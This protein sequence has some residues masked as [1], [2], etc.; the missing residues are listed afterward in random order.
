MFCLI[1]AVT[2][3]QNITISSDSNSLVEGSASSVTITGTID[4]ASDSDIIIP[5]TL[6]GT[7]SKGVDYSVSF[8]SFESASSLY[9]ADGDHRN[10]ISLSDGRYIIYENGTDNLKIIDFDD[11]SSQADVSL[12]RSY[13]H[14]KASSDLILG[15]TSDKIYQL[16][17]SGNTVSESLY[18]ELEDSQGVFNNQISIEGSNI[19]FNSLNNSGERNV[20]LKQGSNEPEQIY[21]GTSC[22][23]VPVLFQ[24]RAIMFG[25]NQSYFSEI[26]NNSYTQTVY[27]NGPSQNGDLDVSRDDIKVFNNKIYVKPAYSIHGPVIWEVNVD[28]GLLTPVLTSPPIYASDPS[29]ENHDFTF[30]SSGNLIHIIEPNQVWVTSFQ[31]APE[32]RIPAGSTSGTITFSVID[33]NSNESDE[34]IIITPGT[35]TNGTLADNSD[36]N[37]TISDDD[38]PSVV[39][40]AFS[41]ETVSEPNGSVTLTATANP[42]SGLDIT[43]PLTLSGTASSDEYSVSASE[44]VIPAGSDSASVTITAVDDTEVEEMQTIIFTIGE[45]TNGTTVTTDVTL[46]LDSDDDP[47]ITSIVG[48]PTTFAENESS[49]VSATINAVSS[50]DI[51]IPFTLS[52]TATS[53]SDY[54]STFDS[55]GEET[56]MM[57]INENNNEFSGFTY[58][59]GKYFFLDWSTLRVFDPA[60]QTSNTYYLPEGLNSQ[61]KIVGNFIYGANGDNYLKKVDISDLNN[62]TST[63]LVSTNDPIS[64]QGAFN[65]IDGTIYYQTY[66][67]ITGVW[68]VYS[69]VEGENSVQIDV[70]NSFNNFIKLGETL[71]GI[72]GWSGLRKYENGEFSDIYVSS[73]YYMAGNNNAKVINDKLYLRNGNSSPNHV[74]YGEIVGSSIVYTQLEYNTSSDMNSIRDF[75]FDSSNG[76]L[77]LYN[78]SS[79]GVYSVFS[80]Q[81]S[82]E[83]KIP[84]GSTTGTI[85]FT[86]VEDTLDEADETLILTPGTPTNGTLSDTSEIILTITDLNDPS[87]VTFAFSAETVSEPNG[88]V[89]LT[90]TADPVSGLDV[91]IPFTLSGTAGS[92]EYSVSASEIVIPAGSDSASVTITALDDDEVEVL[93]T[94]IFTI[95]ELTNGTTET[96]EVTLNLESD[97]DPDVTSIVGSPTTFAENESSTVTATINAASSRDVIIPLTISGTATSETDFTSTFDSEEEET[98]VNGAFGYREFMDFHSDGR[99][100][101]INSNTLTIYEPLNASTTTYS[102]VRS[103]EWHQVEGD[104]IYA[105]SSSQGLET[106]RIDISDLNNIEE[107][108]YIENPT[109]GIAWTYN[110]LSVENGN[111]LYNVYNSNA[112]NSSNS[113][114]VFKKEPGSDPEII[115]EGSMCCYAPILYNDRVYQIGEYDISEIVNGVYTN[116]RYHGGQ[117]SDLK[118]IKVIDGKIYFRHDTNNISYFSLDDEGAPDDGTDGWMAGYIN[119]TNVLTIPNN[120]NSIYTFDFD[121]QMN[122]YTI[123]WRNNEYNLFSYQLSPEIKIPAGSTTGTITFTGVEDTLDEADETLILTPGTPTNGTLSDA[124]ALTLTIT[125]I[126]D[127][128]AVTF[129]FSAETVSEP[130]GSVTLTATADPVS[131]FDI[132]VP[133]TLSGTASSDQYSV[134]ATEIVIPAGSYSASV[135]ITAVDDTEVE[136]LETIVFTIGEVTNGTTE[137]T[138]VTL[139][140]GSEDQPNSSLVATNP[141]M[142]EGESTSITLEIDAAT[143]NDVIVPLVL[144][145]TAT[146]NIDYTTDFETEGQETFLMNVNNDYNR[147]TILDDGRVVFLQSSSIH[148]YDTVNKTYQNYY[149]DEY[150]NYLQASGDFIYLKSNQRIFKFNIDQFNYAEDGTNDI[151]TTLISGSDLLGSNDYYAGENIT[152]EGDKLLYQVYDWPNGYKVYSKEGENDAELIYEGGTHANHLLLFNDRVYKFESSGMQELY[153]GEYT[154]Y[155]NYDYHIY[156]VLAYNNQVY[157]LV[158][159]YD[160]NLGQN[161]RKVSKLNIETDIINANGDD[162]TYEFMP[163]V[164]GD[165]FDYFYMFGFDNLGN[166]VQFNSTF[167]NDNYAYGLYSYQLFPEILISA[168]ETSGTFTFESIEDSSF[169]DDETIIVTPGD[170]IN[171]TITSEQPLELNIIDDDNPP[172]ITFELSSETIVENSETSVTLTA[173]ADVQ[174]G[175]EITIPFTMGGDALADEY[176]L[177]AE[178][179]VIA[180]NA[181]TGSITVTTFGIDDNAVEVSESIVFT[182]GEITNA[183]T[184]TT[185]ITLTL[186]S[187]DNPTVSSVDISQTELTEGESTTLTVTVD[188]AGSNDV[189]VPIIFGGSATTEVDYNSTFSAQGEQSLIGQLSDNGFSR[190]GILSDGRHVF[191]NSSEIRIMSADASSENS[192]QLGSSYWWMEIE[193][194]TIYIANNDRIAIVD[195]TDISSNQVEV[196]EIVALDNVNINGYNFSVENGKVLYGVSADGSGTRQVWL[197]ESL[198]TDPVLLGSG[199]SCCYKPILYNGNV[200]RFETGGYHQLIDGEETNFVSYSGF[201]SYINRDRKMVVKNGILYGF[202]DYNSSD[203]VQL[204]LDA[205]NG[206]VSQAFNIDIGEEINTTRT[207]DFAPNGNI[208]LVNEVIEN[209]ETITQLNSYLMNAE[210]KVDAGETTG[211][212]TINTIDD[213]SFEFDE[214]ITVNYGTP[215]NANIGD[216]QGSEIIILD[217]DLPPVVTFELSSDNIVE[218][219]TDPVT[220][221]ATLSE[222]SGYDVT[223]PFTISGTAG[224]DEYSVSALSIVIPAGSDS[225]SV[226]VSTAELDDEEVEMLETIIFT[227]GELTNASTETTEIILNLE[228]DDDPNLVSVEADPLE[229]AEHESATVTATIDQASSRDVI[230]P[231][232]LSGTAIFDTDY[233]VD[234][235]ALGEENLFNSLTE[236]YTD[237][238][239]LEDGRLIV[240]KSYYELLIFEL[241]GSITSIPLETNATEFKVRGSEIILRD[242]PTMSKIDLNTLTQSVIGATFSNNQIAQYREGFDYVNNK[243]FTLVRSNDNYSTAIHSQIQGE[244]LVVIGNFND[245]PGDYLKS[246]AVTSDEEIF[247]TRQNENSIYKLVDGELQ[248]WA[249]YDQGYIQELRIFNDQLYAKTYS[250][251]DGLNHVVLIDQNIQY[252]ITSD[253]GANIKQL[254]YQLSDQVLYVN[255]FVFYNNDLYLSIQNQQNGHQI[256]SYSFNPEIVIPSGNLSG[257]LLIEGIDDDL[258]APGEETDET[259]EM[260]I[261]D[262]LN[263]NIE[264]SNTFEDITLTILNNEIDLALDED[265]LANVPAMTSSSVAWGDFD[266]DGDQDMAVMGVSFFDGVITRLYENVEGIF[267][268]SNPGIFAPTYEGDLMWVDYNKDG[269]IDLVVSGLDPND[270]PSTVIYEN[271]DG[272]T[273]SPS[274]DMTLPNLFSTS[275]D[276]GDLD[277]DGDIDFIINGQDADNNWRKY[278]YKREGTQL[279]LEGDYN[280]QFNG[281]QGYVDGVMRIADHS[282]DGDLD[283]YMLGQ[284]DSRIKTNTYINESSEQNWWGDQL[285]NVQDGSMTFFGDYVY[286]MGQDSDGTMRFY[287]RSLDGYNNDQFGI[288]GLKDGDIAIGDYNNDGYEDMVITGENESAESITKLYDGNAFGFTENTEIDLVGLRSSTAKWVDYDMDGDLDL[289]LNGT[290]DEGEFSLLYKTNLENKTN[291]AASAITNLSFENLG[292]GKVRLSWDEPEDDFSNNLGYVIRLGTT[293]F[294]SELSNTESNLETGQRLIT[295][296]TQINSNS[297]EALLDP[298]NYYWSVQSVDTGLRGSV[299]SDEATFQLTYEWKL[300]NQGGII[301][302]SISSIDQPIVKLTDIDGDNDM[303]LVYGSR[304]ADQDIQIFRLGDNSFEYFDY[305]NDARSITDIEFLD[306]NNDLVLDIIVNTWNGPQSNF[307]RLYNSNSNGG[308]NSV[309]SAPGLYQAK[310]ELIDINNDG[311]EEIIHAGRTSESA[312]SELKIYVYEQNGNTLTDQPLDIS[313]QVS[314]LKQGAF[315]FG[316]IDLDEDIDFG[317]TGLSNFG[318]QSNVYLNETVFTET[319]APIFALT[320]VDFPAAYESTLDFIDFDGDGDLDIMLTGTGSNGPMFKVFANN[321]LGGDQLDFTEAQNTGLTPIRNA[322]IDYGDYNGD[323]YLDILYTGTVTGQGEV[324]KLME[325]DPDT[326]S[327]IESDFDLSDIVNAS[328]AFGDVD[329][330]NDLDFTIA[331]ESSSN[332]NNSIIKTYLNVRNESADVVASS[333]GGNMTDT[334]SIIASFKS[335]NQFIVNDRPSTPDGLTSSIESY[336]AVSNTYKVKFMWNASF[337]DHTPSEALTYGLKIGTSNGGD[338]IMKVNALSNGYRLSAGKG[339]VEQSIEWI[340]NLPED[341][342]YWS[343]QAID[344]SFSG[345]YFSTI[346]SVFVVSDN[347]AL[348]ITS[349]SNNSEFDENTETVEIEFDTANFVISE[350][351]SGDGYIM[352]SINGEAQTALYNT[353]SITINVEVASYIIEMWLV[354][355]DGNELDPSVSES[356]SFV[357]GDPS[358]IISLM[359]KGIIDF[360][361]PEG[362]T[363]G[364][365][366]HLFAT[367]NISDLSNYGIG[368]AN[369][370]GG[371]DGLELTLPPGISAT[372]G[373]H[374]LIVRDQAAMDSYMNASQIFDYVFVND[375]IGQNGDD[376]IELYYLGE[377]IEVFG[378]VDTDGTGEAWEYT[379][380]WAY[381]VDDVWIYGTVNCTDGSTTTCDSSCPYPFVVCPVY[382]D[383]TFSVDMTYYPG[384]FNPENDTVYVNGSF[385]N[386]CGDCNPMENTGSGIWTTTIPVENGN[387]EYKFTINGFEITESYSEDADSC[388]VTGSSGDNLL[389]NGDID[390]SN[391]WLGIGNGCFSGGNFY[392][393]TTQCGW[394]DAS[395]VNYAPSNDQHGQTHSGD[396][397]I[398]TYVAN[399]GQGEFIAQEFSQLPMGTYSFS[400]FH[401]WTGGTPDYSSGAPTFKILQAAEAGTWNEV[402]S[403]DLSVGNIGA[404]AEWTENSGSWINSSVNDYR[405]VIHKNGYN[406]PGLAKNLHLDTISFMLTEGDTNRYF[407]VLD[408]DLFLPTVHWNLCPGQDPLSTTEESINS[409]IIYPNPV[410]ENRIVTILSPINGEMHIEIFSLTGRKILSKTSIGNR[411][412][413]SSLNSGFY[414]MKVTINNQ[415]KIFKLVVK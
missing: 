161:L 329:G 257:S 164:Y 193:G 220:M 402:Y 131:G 48:S 396:R 39:T 64:I 392:D 162:G 256:N 365:A 3:S 349:P 29:P 199:L 355:N 283:I 215:T 379:D 138:D 45:V 348:S 113:R 401:K 237:F 149:M 305:I 334:G 151:V 302:R 366:I 213:D 373:E 245:Y 223:I 81:L 234:F 350:D 281:D 239:F 369:N 217:N 274:I 410:L 93:E 203:L 304:S 115:Y 49:T 381:K 117:I 34:T 358:S 40:F 66:Q 394:T 27:L 330:D 214:N 327:Y 51:N 58:S 248:L 206:I 46:N 187:E 186:L 322:N 56:L 258:N 268:N 380:S 264:D 262:P 321:G 231:I 282:I 129:A 91:T 383:V 71:Y 36:V 353:N 190:F 84:A 69:L 243:L 297:Y 323:G 315:G 333:A 14:I 362:G 411:L 288:E 228:S 270:N 67:S 387:Y 165:T 191:L 90:A 195:I 114:F 235:E 77:L 76:D 286:Y 313:E 177:S 250:Y 60:T 132:T 266:R 174:S 198:E 251:V 137:T 344:A 301:D 28:S 121:S 126:N 273:F 4:A 294:G 152:V 118:E 176:E 116:Y 212:I 5:I 38:N 320:S 254:D 141:D 276:S 180:P 139:N 216:I 17:I 278:I 155:I 86:G 12:A 87:A 408:E 159:Y 211:S 80:Y 332:N 208:I 112:F 107:E 144:T 181:T 225:G 194:N 395:G 345:S 140:L 317:I 222:I 399:D 299:F 224:S 123:E 63:T 255:D 7:G 94:I 41:A 207:F 204:S 393:G 384:E 382:N 374:I 111:V 109:D 272:V 158:E 97:D 253:P 83:I 343:V 26:V 209:N 377:V 127:P 142:N 314:G 403:Q 271:I 73:Q 247:V 287:R 105:R 103:Y 8:S 184:E 100:M 291:T 405:I 96:T 104:Y 166:L 102:L 230:V 201:T 54:T 24:G 246:I 173:T 415:S 13:N 157:A 30:D 22:C 354:D 170:P 298:G 342:Y 135:T 65:V 6:T 133:L 265:A 306:I 363:S 143:S 50:R 202:S 359:L 99:L 312:N 293:E 1:H 397:M 376:A 252:T 319:V 336:D 134:S 303:D 182:F 290:N 318:A 79:L 10:I 44:I 122:L 192:A 368:I 189:Y 9:N 413:V 259:I 167:E 296:S 124:S 21:S 229:F 52:G 200:Y 328:I 154:N 300:L 179:I 260:S 98:L 172:M 269:Y 175:V 351:G 53:E 326:S 218:N 324:T 414:T 407:E 16:S 242:W 389:P 106:Y 18:L 339:N 352:W 340:L 385:N 249:Y 406:N 59:N 43:V 19:L 92:D 205:G 371:T 196:E 275:M 188:A 169:E 347:P 47:E 210:L 337:D 367:G 391:G 85:T 386:W 70:G 240:L 267:V 42:V 185:S 89:T 33:D 156:Q 2:F 95:G 279:I 55:K 226:E 261:L 236:T 160:A 120:N 88:S 263:A 409:M 221:T 219:A 148:V 136:V 307:L 357:V 241:D 62:I 25:E 284:S 145:G 232:S 370:G 147:M 197:L 108:L 331:G 57:I 316:N 78:Q 20:Y 375:G 341:T 400:F 388:T 15:A 356:T 183:I 61:H 308:F 378:D 310:I 412:D 128:S 360:S 244:D 295:K 277:N 119:F 364:K 372:A 130:N 285:A 325:F 37:V 398:K 72:D 309:F 238:N 32:I 74:Y 311:T 168:G 31:L 227:F 404:N 150:A 82:P 75:D 35:P 292:N 178:S 101:S 23:W 233:S 125:D 390:T 338:E 280:N 110:G 163:T 11:Q 361:V 289:F 153:N 146:F 171:A 346:E 335:E 68:R